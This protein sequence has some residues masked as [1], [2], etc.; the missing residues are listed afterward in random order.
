[1][2]GAALLGQGQQLLESDRA[3]AVKQFEAAEPLQ[4]ESLAA[5]EKSLESPR[6]PAAQGVSAALQRLVA[7][8]QSWEKP[9]ETAK[10]RARLPQPA[11][12]PPGPRS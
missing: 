5:L 12:V 8:Y 7:L 10:W 4:L 11:D 6:P 1:M 2:L 9:A 3:T